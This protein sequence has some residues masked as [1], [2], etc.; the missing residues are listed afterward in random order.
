MST[1]NENIRLVDN[2]LNFV[3]P[4]DRKLMKINAFQIGRAMLQS[5]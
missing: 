5:S 4:R 1:I 2:K 3:R